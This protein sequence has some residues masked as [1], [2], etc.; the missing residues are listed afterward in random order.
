MYSEFDSNGIKRSFN[1][2]KNDYR[3]TKENLE[4]YLETIKDMG[5][6]HIHLYQ[7]Q[8][9]ALRFIE[10]YYFSALVDFVYPI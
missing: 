2:P 4:Y 10:N 6:K 3:W 1:S 5:I 8:W 7:G 9:K